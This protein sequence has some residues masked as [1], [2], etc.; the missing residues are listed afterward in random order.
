MG[1]R[2]T[3]NPLSLTGLP[4]SGVLT[5]KSECVLDSSSFLS[6]SGT[7]V[8]SASTASGGHLVGSSVSPASTNERE[9]GQTQTS[10]R[11]S[12]SSRPRAGL[13]SSGPG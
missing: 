10:S 4:L 7:N 11:R 6:G 2:Y 1:K 8:P 3:Y 12:E 13:K 9:Q 5:L